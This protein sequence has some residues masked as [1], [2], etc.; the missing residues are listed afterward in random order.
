MQPRVQIV[1][2]FIDKYRVHTGNVEVQKIKDVQP[3]GD[4]KGSRSFLGLASYHRLFVEGYAKIASLLSGEHQERSTSSMRA[5][6]KRHS[7]CSN[8]H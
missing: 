8:W 1:G 5:K 2:H 3:L 7:T 6:W 4:A